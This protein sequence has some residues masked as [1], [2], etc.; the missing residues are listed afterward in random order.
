MSD[1]LRAGD[2]DGFFS[3]LWGYE[4]FPW[5]RE[6]V[7]RLCD[8]ESDPERDGDRGGWPEAID[9][10]TGS[11]KTACIDTAVFALAVQASLPAERRTAPR[12]IVLCVDRR[13][14][15][16]EACQ[17]AR[18]IA[19][20]LRA[21]GAGGVIGRVAAAL[22]LVAGAGDDTSH[23]PLDAYELRGGISRDDTW[24]RSIAQPTV[25]ATTVDQLGS[26][27]LFRG[28]G[29]WPGSRPIHAGLFAFDSVVL[30]DEAHISGP[31]EQTLEAVRWFSDRGDWAERGLGVRPMRLVTMTATPSGQSKD[32]LRLGEDDRD[33]PVLSE[34]LKAEKIARLIETKKGK[35]EASA[36]DEA[37]AHLWHEG[38]PRTVAVIVN[39]VAAAKSV[40]ATLREIAGKDGFDVELMIGSM[41]PL[42]R[43]RQIARMRTVFGGGRCERD[44]PFVLVATQCVEVGADYDF[45]A[46]ITQCASLEALRQRFGRLNRGGR[47]IETR[48]VILM[49][50][51][52]LKD[53]DKLDDDKPLD[54]VYGNAMARTWHWLNEIASS[55]GS[56]APGVDVGIEAI[57]GRVAR[58]ESDDELGPLLSPHGDRRAPVMLPAYLDALSQTNPDPAVGPDVALFLRGERGDPPDVSVCWRADL[59]EQNH[60]H[61]RKIVEL[62]PPASPECMP[63]PF[64]RFIRWWKG[65]HHR[66]KKARKAEVDADAPSVFAEDERGDDRARPDARLALLWNAQDDDADAMPREPRPG[67]TIVLPIE[68][69]QEPAAWDALGHVPDAPDLSNAARLDLAEE[70]SLVSRRCA[71]LR[72]W[73]GRSWPIVAGEESAASE[74]EG[75]QQ[76]MGSA[77][78]PARTPFEKL[79]ERVLDVENPAEFEERREL[80]SEIRGAL[81][82]ESG[83]ARPLRVMRH[84]ADLLSEKQR[85]HHAERG[86]DGTGIVVLRSAR[87]VRPLAEEADVSPE[88]V[89]DGGDVVGRSVPVELQAHTADVVD[90]TERSLGVLPVPDDLGKVLLSAAE[91]HDW[92][93]A[94]VRFQAMLLGCSPAEARMYRAA[95]GP[96][97]TDGPEGLGGLLAKSGRERIRHEEMRLRERAELPK[98][99]RHEM[100]SVQLAERALCH[101]PDRARGDPVLRDLL[102][103][104]IASHHG[105]ARPFAS[106]VI[107]ADPHGV[108]VSGVEMTADDRRNAV[109]PHRLDSGVAERFWRLTRVFGW[110]GLAY[111][112]AILRLAD[113]EASAQEEA[114]APSESERQPEGATA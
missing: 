27:L 67:D 36:I 75:G 73:P 9:V 56:D 61:W 18:T 100:L 37:R 98:G 109:P 51:A 90:A 44:R 92:G 53:P 3:E 65:E 62:C 85:I 48:A 108:R 80:L 43:E 28:Y 8:P 13:V 49:D 31:F 29:V 107:D 50:P 4:P 88:S 34:R 96:D 63:V 94:D 15:V 38:T 22:R 69:D 77:E 105:S 66:N 81:P 76:S 86:P 10:P 106:V 89:D 64:G 55:D 95:L 45:D 39:R 47:P 26:R 52:D 17:R 97:G 57:E 14:V 113:W 2:F 6:L 16:S 87:G 83:T 68:T 112:E 35:L 110:W 42:D 11:G 104:L 5:Q 82:D 60:D 23:P 93:K 40:H 99:F 32:V 25:I 7:E 102:L 84:I 30:L 54:P 72:L 70:A 78:E 19:G 1:G 114:E 20:K 33:H 101:A 79:R 71:L 74:E 59:N 24:A 12:R 46:M 41:R 21:E 103:H 91:M 58:L 111:L